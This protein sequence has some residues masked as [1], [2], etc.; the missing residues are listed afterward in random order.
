MKTKEQL[1]RFGQ[2]GSALIQGDIRDEK[3]HRLARGRGRPGGG[4]EN[5]KPLTAKVNH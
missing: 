3:I 4:E 5:D 2:R 1:T